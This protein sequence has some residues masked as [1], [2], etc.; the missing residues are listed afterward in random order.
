MIS[1][2]SDY[3]HFYNTIVQWMID[4]SNPGEGGTLHL[5]LKHIYNFAATPKNDMLTESLT[6]F[7]LGSKHIGLS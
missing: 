3:G 7:Y 6:L 4:K 5:Y 2:S 1:I